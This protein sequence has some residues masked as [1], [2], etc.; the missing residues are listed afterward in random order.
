MILT[1]L[2]I[3]ISSILLSLGGCIAVV[4]NESHRSKCTHITFPCCTIDRETTIESA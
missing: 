3:F 4:C 2:G 1:E